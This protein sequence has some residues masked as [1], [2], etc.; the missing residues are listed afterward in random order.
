[1]PCDSITRFLC[2][3]SNHLDHVKLKRQ[4]S[5]LNTKHC[6]ADQVSFASMLPSIA[7]CGSIR[8]PHSKK[9]Q[10]HTTFSAP[11]LYVWSQSHALCLQR[12]VTP[13]AAWLKPYMCGKCIIVKLT[14]KKSLEVRRGCETSRIPHFLDQGFSTWGKRTPLGGTPRHLWRHAKASYGVCKSWI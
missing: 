12:N 1:M 3:I 8:I 10:S 4:N 9:C 2:T 11:C 14:T 5:S 7:F 13:A 6:T